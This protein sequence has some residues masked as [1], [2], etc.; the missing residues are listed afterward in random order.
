MVCY[1][2]RYAAAPVEKTQDQRRSQGLKGDLSLGCYSLHSQ[3]SLLRHIPASFISAAPDC[4]FAPA[5]AGSMQWRLWLKGCQRD[6]TRSLL[7]SLQ[8]WFIDCHWFNTRATPG[9]PCILS[10]IK[11]ASY[12]IDP[13]L[14]TFP[15][16]VKPMNYV[17]H[18]LELCL[19][20]VCAVLWFS[21]FCWLHKH[22]IS[23]VD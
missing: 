9:F 16:R 20:L 19:G 7:P 8:P 14:K 1:K 12:S 18:S 22:C 2:L 13:L 11:L 21:V 3:N 15:Q 4:R 10:Q 23:L 5:P 17:Q 6:M